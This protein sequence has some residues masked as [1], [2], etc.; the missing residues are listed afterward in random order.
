MYGA[1]RAYGGSLP[2]PDLI[3]QPIGGAHDT[4]VRGGGDPNFARLRRDGEALLRVDAIHRR[5]RF[6]QYCAGRR[7]IHVNAAAGPQELLEAVRRG[8]SDLSA[9]M[10]HDFPTRTG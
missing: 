6:Q 7:T 5:A 2:R 8:G 10:I 1:S 4:A 9:G 3:L